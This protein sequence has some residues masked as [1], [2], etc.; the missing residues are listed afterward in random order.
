MST[1]LIL[2]GTGTPNLLPDR[3][4]S[5]WA[6]IVE[7]TPYL[8]DCGGGSMQRISQAHHYKNITALAMP[9]LSRLFLTHLHPDHTAGLPDLILAPWVG[10]REAPLQIFGP[11]GTQALC[12]HILAGYATGIAEHRDG[13]APINHPLRVEVTEWD[14]TLPRLTYQDTLVQVQAFRVQHGG[15]EAYGYKFT[16]SDKTIVFS[17]DTCP[18]PTL[19]E[20]AQGCD[21]LVHEVYSAERFKTRPTDWQTYHRAV[22]TSTIELAQ[23]AR[24]VQPRLLVLTHQLFWGASEESLLKEIT[25]L[26]EGVVVSGRDLDVFQD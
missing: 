8:V 9:N 11:R 18:S 2:L 12:D 13:L 14:A 24:E 1:Q 17:G 15:L 20:M 6:V 3:F 10:M 26:Y 4:Q 25:D 5:A 7:N 21:I 16:T 23:I 19:I 22:H